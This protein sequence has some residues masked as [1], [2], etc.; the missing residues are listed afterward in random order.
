MQY[1]M[2]K[3]TSNINIVLFLVFLDLNAAPKSNVYHSSPAAHSRPVSAARL[4]TLSPAGSPSSVSS[5]GSSVTSPTGPCPLSIPKHVMDDRNKVRS[6]S[7]PPEHFDAPQVH[8]EKNRRQSEQVGIPTCPINFQGVPNGAFSPTGATPR[9][10]L[11]A[12][13]L[14]IP[15]ESYNVLPSPR[16]LSR[17]S[18]D[19]L[20]S[21]HRIPR[22]QETQENYHDVPFPRPINRLASPSSPRG[23]QLSS[24]HEDYDV[25]PAP[26]PVSQAS[27]RSSQE[28]Y[29]MV[30]PPRPTSSGSDTQEGLY[31]VPPLGK[32]QENENYDV[33]P[34]PRPTS[35][36]DQDL[37][38]VP[39]IGKAHEQDNYD[40]VP[41]PRR[42]SYGDTHGGQDIYDVPPLGRAQEQENYDIVPQPRSVSSYSD[43]QDGQGRYDV[44]PVGKA[45]ASEQANYDILPPLHRP[46]QIQPD[47]S[48]ENYDVVPIPRRAS[49]EVYDVVPPARATPSG[50]MP[51]D[52]GDPRFSDVHNTLS[53]E[54]TSADVYD[55]VPP[56]IPSPYQPSQDVYD[57]VPNNARPVSADSGLNASYSSTC[58]L[59]SEGSVSG[60]D[61]K[62]DAPLP[63]VPNGRDSGSL[64]DET[65]DYDHD[66]EE[67]YDKPPNLASRNSIYDV[68]PKLETLYDVL[69]TH[70]SE[71]YDV[72]PTTSDDIYDVPPQ[73]PSQGNKLND[74]IVLIRKGLLMLCVVE[75]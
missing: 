36:D 13:S 46:R 44:L 66:P 6:M 30:P 71:I 56:P 35:C 9:R 72:A 32:T 33:V 27:N 52:G 47:P 3:S 43:T 69:P 61:D 63:P 75:I 31:D 34:L 17:D 16:S 18:Y 29:D 39:P 5:S 28:V 40:I 58:S 38:D 49:Q 15:S 62:Y 8:R 59:K 68:P 42:T 14:G 2:Y 37:Y 65:P 10:D 23:R 64:S 48:K 73:I 1:I 26:R 19:N 21:P 45:L 51:R 4:H 74:D 7:D 53:N 11:A 12:L 24:A 54:R 57:T 70:P 60:Q 55:W 22:G 41:L 20:P 67:I 25:V 50:S